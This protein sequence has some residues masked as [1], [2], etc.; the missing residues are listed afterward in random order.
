VTRRR[1]AAGVASGLSPV[2]RGHVTSSE[3]IRDTRVI[4]F[5]S[6]K[7]N[8]ICNLQVYSHTKQGSSRSMVHIDRAHGIDAIIVIG[9]RRGAPAIVHPASLRET[10]N[11]TRRPREPMRRGAIRASPSGCP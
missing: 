8:R 9:F 11:N 7:A 4:D 2:R 10:L 5:R 6:G 1:S 3:E